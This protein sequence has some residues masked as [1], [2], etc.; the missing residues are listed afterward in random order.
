VS[1]RSHARPSVAN[2]ICRPQLWHRPL[3]R[4]QPQRTYPRP[5]VQHA[6]INYIESSNV[7]PNRTVN[8]VIASLNADDISWTSKL[9]IPNLNI[10]RYVS[11]A[12]VGPYYPPVPR[13]GREA[14]IYLTYFYQFY[15]KLPDISIMIH[16]HEDPWHIEGVLQQSMLFTLSHLDLEVVHRRQYANLRVDWT[17]ACPAWIDTTKTPKTAS[18]QEEPYM[19]A[20]LVEN[21]GMSDAEVPKIMSGPCCAQFAVTKEAVLRNP[22]S[23][24]KRSM[25]WLVATRLSDYLSG[26]TWE[27]MWPVLFRG[28]AI[29]CPPEWEVYCA[30]YHICFENRDGPSEYN[31]LWREKEAL[32]EDTEFW[33]EILNPHAGF[34]ARKRIKEIEL[35]LEAQIFVALERG[36]EASIRDDIG[37]LY[38]P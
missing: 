20:A 11:D 17:Q 33:R 6:P 5:N 30:M 32:K 35:L 26:R 36:K 1:F 37:S 7:G 34:R 3:Q 12:P 22:R 27:H 31:R 9:D 13:K 24:Y 29:D 10:I 25:D 28:E 15:D 21:F 14:L 23:Q 4:Y 2:H 16:P 19:H 38:E 8:L 18:K